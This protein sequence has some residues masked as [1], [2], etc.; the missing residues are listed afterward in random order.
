MKSFDKLLRVL[1]SDD[2]EKITIDRKDLAN[3][4]NEHLELTK[5]KETFLLLSESYNLYLKKLI[6][7][8]HKNA[9]YQAY[10]QVIE[11]ILDPFKNIEAFYDNHDRLSINKWIE[12]KQEELSLN[13]EYQK[14]N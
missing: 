7:E 12:L 14:R 5:F 10:K 2:G 1:V 11:F 4:V 8:E 3:V 13:N 6:S 9:S